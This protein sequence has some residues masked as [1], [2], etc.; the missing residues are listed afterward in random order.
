MTRTV[1]L[2]LVV[3]AWFLQSAAAQDTSARPATTK[4]ASALAVT[5]AALGTGVQ[6]R[7]LVGEATEFALNQK[8]YLW[9]ALSGGPADGIVV[10][11]KQGEKTYET[12]LNV[13]GTTWHTWA[14]KTAAVGGPWEVTVADAAGNVL[15][16][17]EFT[18]GTK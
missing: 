7:K 4:A 8:V 13:G 6:D 11:W 9:L 2:M 14:Y 5:E 16:K 10:T 12:K 1:A 18:V 17:L 3:C 15:K